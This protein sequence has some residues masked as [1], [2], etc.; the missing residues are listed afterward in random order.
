MEQSKAQN[1]K[2]LRTAPD[3]ESDKSQDTRESPVR[4]KVVPGSFFMGL[5]EVRV[6][7]R[8]DFPNMFCVIGAETGGMDLEWLVDNME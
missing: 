8:A 1:V 4:R 2:R 6:V 3:L 7:P 5:K